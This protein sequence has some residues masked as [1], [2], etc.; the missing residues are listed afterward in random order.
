MSTLPV[1]LYTMDAIDLY[2]LDFAKLE[3]N[4]K[5]KI[6]EEKICRIILYQSVAGQQL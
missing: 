5:C 1:L 3:Y 2:Y 4:W 6:M